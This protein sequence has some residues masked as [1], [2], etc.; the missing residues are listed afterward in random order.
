VAFQATISILDTHVSL[1][2]STNLDR[3]EIDIPD[4]LIDLLQA[5]EAIE[6]AFR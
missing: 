5:A 1:K 3:S 2:Q 4:L 6:P